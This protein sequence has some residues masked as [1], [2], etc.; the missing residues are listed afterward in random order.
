MT[1]QINS[2]LSYHN[3]IFPSPVEAPFASSEDIRARAKQLIAPNVHGVILLN[4]LSEPGK[5]G[6]LRA[7]EILDQFEQN[8]RSGVI[9]G[10][11]NYL[12][13]NPT[14]NV[15]VDALFQSE[16]FDALG[17]DIGVGSLK[18]FLRHMVIHVGKR[19]D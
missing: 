7:Q 11:T 15:Q 3:G 5:T 10:I 19:V 9:W 12:K 14:G 16:L 18:S 1:N 4:W 13:S 2:N 6:N 8:P 17:I